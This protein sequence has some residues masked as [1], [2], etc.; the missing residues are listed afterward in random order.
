MRDMISFA[1]FFF[2]ENE[3]KIL[4]IGNFVSMVLVTI[5]AGMLS[6]IYLSV[7]FAIAMSIYENRMPNDD[8]LETIFPIMFCGLFGVIVA[9]AY[10][11]LYG[12]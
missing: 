12:G 7:G 3:Q 1:S 9:E 6:G 5:A 4:R 11:L 8:P 10:T 2:K